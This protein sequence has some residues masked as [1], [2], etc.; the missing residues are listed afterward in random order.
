MRVSR[1]RRTK[2]SNAHRPDVHT[3]EDSDRANLRADRQAYKRTPSAWRSQ[4]LGRR[5]SRSEIRRLSKDLNAL[6]S[7]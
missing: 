5:P 4:N 6:V 3:R 7:G 1:A 2:Q